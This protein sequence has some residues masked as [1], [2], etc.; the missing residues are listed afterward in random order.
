MKQIKTFM[1]ICFIT[2]ITF[3]IISGCEKKEDKMPVPDLGEKLK[4]GQSLG[5]KSVVNL[6]DVG[7]YPTKT[8]EVVRRGLAYRSNELNPV[9][10]ESM[11]KIAELGL[12]Y[13]FDLRTNEEVKEKPDELPK[14]VKYEQLNILADAKSAAPAELEKLMHDPKKANEV[15]GGGKIDD[16]F[17]EGYR[18]FV[19][20]PSALEGYRKLFLA[21][22]TPKDLPSLFHCTTGKDR[23]GW[24]SAALL[25]LLGVD[26][27][28]VMQDFLKSNEYILPLYQKDIDEFVAAGGEKE[29]AL[30]IFGVKREYLDASFD[31]VTKNYGTLENYFA[32]GLG[33]DEEGQQALR[34]LYLEKK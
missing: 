22:G 4:P 32:E 2:I 6:R 9:S 14:G 3:L 13:D 10:P 11:K 27:E 19:S 34:N 16:L 20:L 33:I 23:T 29:I 5:I 30:A 7:G 31:E 17:I 15:F 24:A 26:S 12:I 8:G 28:L 1:I 21:L 18:E 25:T